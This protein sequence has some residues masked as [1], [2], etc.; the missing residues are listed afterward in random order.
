ML[1]DR[2]NRPTEVT[3]RIVAGLEQRALALV[4]R[5]DLREPRL[6]IHAHRAELQDRE[7]LTVTADPLLPEED[8][9]AVRPLDGD[10][11][12]EERARWR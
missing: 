5:V 11:R 7:G 8:R 3:P 1:L 10:G 4:E 2:R 9:A 6:G 12:T